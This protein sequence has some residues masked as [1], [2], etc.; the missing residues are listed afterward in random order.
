MSIASPPA[1]VRSSGGIQTVFGQFVENV[2]PDG[3][4]LLSPWQLLFHCRSLIGGIEH[5]CLGPNDELPYEDGGHIWNDSS[6]FD[7]W[8]SLDCWTV[9]ELQNQDGSD[10]YLVFCLLTVGAS[11]IEIHRCPRWCGVVSRLCFPSASA[12]CL[13]GWQLS[14]WQSGQTQWCKPEGPEKHQ[15]SSLDCT[16]CDL[17]SDTGTW[18]TT[19]DLTYVGKADIYFIWLD[20]VYNYKLTARQSASCTTLNAWI[21]FDHKSLIKIFTCCTAMQSS[22][23]GSTPSL[24]RI[25]L[26]LDNPSLLLSRKDTKVRINEE[27]M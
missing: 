13:P 7:M 18:F 21:Y 3:T 26:A 4:P 10:S 12:R 11:C 5:Q 23:E 1:A 2:Q 6:M 16:V 24:V 14:G 9:P 25:S 19:S 15:N 20:Y 17:C 27:C 8:S 22:V